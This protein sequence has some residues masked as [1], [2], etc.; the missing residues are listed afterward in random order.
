MFITDPYFTLK[1]QYDKLLLS[2]EIEGIHELLMWLEQTDFYTA[3]ASTKYHGS[4]ECGLL[5]HSLNVY[6]ALYTL[7]PQ[8]DG[9]GYDKTDVIITALLHDI[10]KIECYEKD[11]RN[12]KERNIEESEYEKWQIKTDSAGK[13]VWKEK[14]VYVFNDQFPFGHGEKSVYLANKFISLTAHQAMAIRYHM[15]AF[16]QDDIQNIS[17][18]FSKYPLALYLHMADMIATYCYDESDE[19]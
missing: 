16:K 8:F 6:S 19:K 9:F 12:Y 3:P 7:L 1:T 10:C 15:G 11:Y 2:T 14:M 13:F 5:Q 17:T 4:H 18:V